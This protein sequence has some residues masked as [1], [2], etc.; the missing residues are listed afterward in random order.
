MPIVSSVTYQ[1]YQAYACS[2]RRSV[3]FNPE[4]GSVDLSAADVSNIE[5]A[6]RVVP[7]IPANGQELAGQ[8]DINTWKLS[9][10]HQTVVQTA[11]KIAPPNGG[12]NLFG[13]LVFTSSGLAG[14]S[15]PL[16][17]SNVYVDHSGLE[18]LTKE[19][20]RVEQ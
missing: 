16:T 1:G 12:F 3:G 10:S 17:Y 8:I 4:R 7:W 18:E 6:G 15:T 5:I 2:Y 20:A 14:N 9:K 13:D 11:A 19:L